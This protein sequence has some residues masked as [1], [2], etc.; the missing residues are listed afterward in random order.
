[1][2]KS[3]F[4][5]RTYSYNSL[6]TLKP[7]TVVDVYGIV[8]FHKLPFKT[9][10][11]DYLMIVTIVDE[12]LIQADEK[13]KCLL[14]AHGEESLPQVKI[15]SIVRFHR[16]RVNLHSGELQGSSGKGF[17]WLV[18]DS[19]SDGCLVPKASSLNYTFTD[20]DRKMIERLF[21]VKQQNQEFRCQDLVKSLEQLK[22]GIY[23]DFVCQVVAVS[24]VEQGVCFLIQV[25]DGTRP[26]CPLFTVEAAERNL[27]M[28]TDMELRKVAKDW[29][30]DVC[31]F[32]DHFQKAATIKP[33]MF[34][35]FFNLHCPKH[36][37]PDLVNP[38]AYEELELVLHRGTSYGRGI[39]ILSGTDPEIDNL[40]KRLEELT[41]KVERTHTSL[42]DP[43]GSPYKTVKGI[44][45]KTVIQG[46]Q[47]VKLSHFC[48][49]KNA[50]VP[51]KFRLLARVMDYSPKLSSVSDF[52][53]LFCPQC[54]YLTPINNYSLEPSTFQIKDGVEYYRCPHCAK[55]T[56]S[57]DIP[58][59]EY[60]FLMKFILTDGVYY[61]IANLW[62]DEAVKFFNNITPLE[63]ISDAEAMNKVR[64]YLE[65][66]HSSE[67][68]SQNL[69][70][71]E[72]CVKSFTGHNSVCYEIFDTL[73]AA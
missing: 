49:V 26:S 68:S 33:G 61:I 54:H 44:K 30:V 3:K 18:V 2:E 55:K 31:V 66:I 16:L 9:K 62:R 57:N 28:Q 53:S 48:D 13:L 39:K 64:G 63:F 38:P 20:V 32:D 59:M 58:V 27:I 15:G 50:T 35:K 1:M 10:G 12:S 19:R 5:T 25:W 17:S 56:N 43:K 11:T 37:T 71:M 24:V 21:C 45:V 47:S 8:K 14:F 67:G 7:N 23:F 51:M 72:C 4:K 36:K 29:L 34:I 41:K 6:I 73:I 40:K 70:M 46:H 52:L 60:I 65:R 22:E 42:T 69:P